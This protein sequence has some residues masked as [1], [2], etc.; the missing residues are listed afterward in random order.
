MLSL[1][2]ETICSGCWLPAIPQS[3]DMISLET[4]SLIQV[5][6]RAP[7]VLEGGWFENLICFQRAGV[8]STAIVSRI[9]SVFILY[10]FCPLGSSQQRPDIFWCLGLQELPL[11]WKMENHFSTI[12]KESGSLDD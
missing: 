9:T 7:L 1:S 12:G 4:R 5:G 8:P 10:W 11:N 3:S 2:Q 6:V